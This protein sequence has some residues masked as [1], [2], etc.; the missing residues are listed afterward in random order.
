MSSTN[1]LGKYQITR[2]IARSND[3]V[4]EAIDPTLGRKVAL[5]ELCLPQNLTGAQKRERIERFHREWKA[6]VQVQHP[7][8]VTIYDAGHDGDRFYI[9]MEY[10]EGQTLR[11]VLQQKGALPVK[12]ALDIALQLCSALGYA[13]QR[14]IVHR[15]VKPENVQILP[16]GHVKLTDFG[17]ARIMSEP[18]ITQNG[19][20]FGT[21]SYMS[22]EQVSGRQIDGRSDIFSMG[23]LLYEM[24]AGQKPFSGDTVVTITYNIMNSEPSPPP[25]VSPYL[26]G[27]I[28]KA[29][30]KDPAMRYQTAEDMA[31]DLKNMPTNGAAAYMD[32]CAAPAPGPYSQYGGMQQPSGHPP[33]KAPPQQL[34]QYTYDPFA[35]SQPDPVVPQPDYGPPPMP[36]GPLLSAETRTFLG[37][38]FLVI[39]LAGLTIFAIWAVNQA[40]VAFAEK[41]AIE[42]S[43]R[44][45][46]Q[47][48]K[49]LND[50]K[51]DAAIQQYSNAIR[52]AGNTKAAKAP[53]L[54]LASVYVEF[55]R[56]ALVNSN[57]TTCAQQA[58]LA[59]EADPTFSAG[60]Y[61]LGISSFNLGDIAKAETELKKAIDTGGNDKFAIAARSD[62][63]RLY[64]Q[65]GDLFV[66]NGRTQEAANDYK[67]AIDLGDPTYGPIAQEKLNALGVPS[68]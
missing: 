38:L 28:R 65:R 68:S 46:T 8:I 55:A 30:S 36:R 54:K 29:M 58:I 42:V 9:A 32:P 59:I 17:I 40:Y 6:A 4:Y 51:V 41:T 39:G 53:K 37:L 16:G 43:Q 21:P 50:G 56:Q 62:L 3:I 12:E 5:K 47:G 14:N 34:G 61:Y 1:T 33:P 27:V 24:L 66:R 45:I 44:Y 19:Q 63:S 25:G 52:A 48:D 22:P 57:N 15:D 35:Y 64:I 7:N 11:E 10:L 13:H 23:V 49:L 2:E 60:H 26:I 67:A 18:T 20:V 31:E